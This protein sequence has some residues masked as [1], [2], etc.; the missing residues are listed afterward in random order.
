MS[1]TGKGQ[2]SAGNSI[3]ILL[4]MLA[5][6]MG[7][8]AL[9]PSLV[10]NVRAAAVVTLEDGIEGC[11]GVRTTPGSENT[12]KELV[13]GS[14]EPGGTASFR[15]TFP[16]EVDG[17]TGQE[18]WKLTDCVFIGDEPFQKFTVTSLENDVSPV[19][20]EFT[21]NI[22]SDAPIGA[23]YCNYGKTTETPSDAQASNRKAGPAC[24][25]IG[26]AL[27]VSK[28][29]GGGMPLAGATF[30]VDCQWPDVEAGTFLPD[31]ILSVPTDGSIEGGASTETINSTDD[32]SFSRS[33]VTATPYGSREARQGAAG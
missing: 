15:F 1:V 8:L 13:G 7:T 22:P 33:V 2:I 16:A 29:D 27:R 4:S 19:V 10:T 6:L 3:V 11:M 9:V 26:G 14:L 12:T 24:F 17:N 5:L 31:T 20:I 18:E 21:L 28:V 23:E 30:T 25:I 32:G